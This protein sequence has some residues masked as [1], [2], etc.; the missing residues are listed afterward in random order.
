MADILRWDKTAEKPVVVGQVMRLTFFFWT[1]CR[2]CL[3]IH[4]GQAADMFRCQA[5]L[6]AATSILDHP[7]GTP[8]MLAK[9]ETQ[10]CSL[11]LCYDVVCLQWSFSRKVVV[12]WFQ[13]LRDQ[14]FLL[15]FFSLSIDHGV[16]GLKLLDAENPRKPL[17]QCITDTSTLMPCNSKRKFVVPPWRIG[18]FVSHAH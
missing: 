15:S 16:R 7:D 6:G 8:G 2:V 11:W 18:H 4:V 17:S 9:R 13:F 1:S 12:C 3:E 10:R 14:K 5:A